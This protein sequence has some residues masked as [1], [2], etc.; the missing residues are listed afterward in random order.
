MLPAPFTIKNKRQ[1]VDSEHTWIYPMV[2]PLVLPSPRGSFP[3]KP[4]LED[5]RPWPIIGGGRPSNMKKGFLGFF[6]CTHKDRP[7]TRRRLEVPKTGGGP[8]S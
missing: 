8:K 7:Q 5:P 3:R 6:Q 4:P 1:L 2:K